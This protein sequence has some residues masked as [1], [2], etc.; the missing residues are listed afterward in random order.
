RADPEAA[1]ARGRAAARHAARTYSWEAVS[2][3]YEALFHHL[4]GGGGS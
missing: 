1:A 4:A 2:R 3:E